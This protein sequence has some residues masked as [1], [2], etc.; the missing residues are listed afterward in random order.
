[1][2]AYAQAQRRREVGVRLALGST[3]GGIVVLVVREGV[4]LAMVGLFA[5]VPMALVAARWTEARFPGIPGPDAV[6]LAAAAATTFGAA[7]A[8]SWIP[9]RRASRVDP[10]VVLR[11]D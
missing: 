10:G 8:A 1:M 5:G 11:A 4:R 2:L 9:A 7:V 6:T 3:P